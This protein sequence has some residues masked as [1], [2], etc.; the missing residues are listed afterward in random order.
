MRLRALS[1]VGGSDR[2]RIDALHLRGVFEDRGKFDREALHLAAVQLE[3]GEC[4]DVPNV[5]GGE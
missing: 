4:R 2:F 5:I 1:G 3:P